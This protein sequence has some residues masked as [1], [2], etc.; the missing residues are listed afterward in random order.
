MSGIAASTVLLWN[1]FSLRL[2]DV[3]TGRAIVSWSMCATSGAAG[4]RWRAFRSGRLRL[5]AKGISHHEPQYRDCFSIQVGY[6][7]VSTVAAA[8][9]RSNFDGGCLRE[10][11]RDDHWLDDWNW[12]IWFHAAQPAGLGR[13]DTGLSVDGNNCRIT[14]TR[15]GPTECEE[16]ERGWSIGALCSFNRDPFFIGRVRVDGGSR[17]CRSGYCV[18]SCLAV[19]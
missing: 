2:V 7:R 4:Y 5:L 11:S 9:P 3:K 15:L 13:T 12:A 6:R 8:D 18:S 10:R 17:D 1:R 16:V 14:R 19:S